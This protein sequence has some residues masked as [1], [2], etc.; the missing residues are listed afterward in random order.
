M[1]ITQK[2]YP[3]FFSRV[4]NETLFVNSEISCQLMLFRNGVGFNKMHVNADD[5]PDF[6]DFAIIPSVK[7]LTVTAE[8]DL[9]NEK[10]NFSIPELTWG[11]P[12]G[13]EF[14]SGILFER[15]GL[16]FMHFDFGGPQNPLGGFT[17]APN[18]L[19]KPHINLAFTP[20]CP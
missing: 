9:A 16:L 6:Q 2:F 20:G 7:D 19:C 1:P 8:L 14:Y 15:E 4:L 17:L 13:E 5:I 12:L 10:L 18:L 3:S 11:S